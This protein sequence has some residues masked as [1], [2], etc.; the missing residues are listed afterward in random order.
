MTMMIMMMMMMMWQKQATVSQPPAGGH[1]RLD[2]IVAQ[3][4]VRHT[5]FVRLAREDFSLLFPP[6][7]DD[8]LAGRAYCD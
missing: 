7:D 4:S 6:A 1:E 5:V 3:I 8:A 2:L